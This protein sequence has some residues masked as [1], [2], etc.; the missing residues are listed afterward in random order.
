MT[1][2]SDLTGAPEGG[3]L[4]DETNLTFAPG[5]RVRIK[6]DPPALYPEDR[7]MSPEQWTSILGAEGTVVE[8][9]GRASG[10]ASFL[11]SVPDGSELLIVELDSPPEWLVEM[12][13]C[14]PLTSVEVE[15]I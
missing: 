7:G 8:D 10:F 2:I 12:G 1:E 6:A 3:S 13:G 14:V 4:L 9:D 11:Y 15:R 5:D